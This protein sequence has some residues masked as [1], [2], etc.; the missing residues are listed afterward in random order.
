MVPKPK[1]NKIK[2]QPEEAT[3]WA[4]LKE[5]V[6]QSGKK[7]PK[8]DD[9]TP[10]KKESLKNRQKNYEK[11]LSDE[12]KTNV[13]FD[14]LKGKGKKGNKKNT[15]KPVKK[16]ETSSSEEES[17]SDEEEAPKTPVVAKQNGKATNGVNTKKQESSEEDSS[18]DSDD[19]DDEKAKPTSKPN[20]PKQQNSKSTPAAAPAKGNVTIFFLFLTLC[21]RLTHT[22]KIQ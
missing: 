5:G 20:T 3:P 16:D 9:D 8:A 15:V 22:V 4:E 19:D 10:S 11:F 12:I 14:T 17:S 2:K 13:E 21:V 18:D 7:Q 1:V 6:L